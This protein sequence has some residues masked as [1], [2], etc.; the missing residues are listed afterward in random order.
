MFLMEKLNIWGGFFFIGYLFGVI[1]VRLV[2]IIVNR[3]FKE[4]G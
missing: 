4:G 1:G 2:I 3:F